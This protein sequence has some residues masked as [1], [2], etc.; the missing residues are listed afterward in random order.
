MGEINEFLKAIQQNADVKELLKNQ[1]KPGSDEEAAEVYASIAEKLGFSVTK[2]DM[3]NGLKGLEK[4]QQEKT[5]ESNADLKQAL[6][7]ADLEQVAGGGEDPRC[8]DTFSP[9][10]W[11]W[12]TDSCSFIIRGYDDDAAPKNV[13]QVPNNPVESN[14]SYP[15]DAQDELEAYD[16]CMV[17][18][19][20]EWQK[21]N[22]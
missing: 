3:L 5:G 18:A 15:Q 20:K 11:C 16:Q 9:G 2:E 12:F 6:D 4:I 13:P 19:M 17:A 14:P 8:G 21:N 1:P 22:K 10:E 7:E